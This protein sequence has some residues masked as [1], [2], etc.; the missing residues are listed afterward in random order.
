MRDMLDRF[1]SEVKELEGGKLHMNK[2]EVAPTTGYGIYLKGQEDTNIYK[3]VHETG[4][5]LKCDIDMG[6]WSKEDLEKVD[7]ELN[8]KD[9][10]YPYTKEFYKKYFSTLG[11]D[12][13]H[14]AIA[15]NIMSVFVNSRSIATL[16]LQKSYNEVIKLI[17]NDFVKNLKPIVEDGKIGKGTRDAVKAL[18]S[19][20]TEEEALCWNSI[21]AV[22]TCKEY[23]SLVDKKPTNKIY[24]NGWLNRVLENMRDNFKLYNQ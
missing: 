18:S 20:I 22:I 16:V 19:N 23:V 24:L 7:A 14:P 2:T 15:I 3:L 21:A 10:Y 17:D 8:N 13:M 1:L 11:I 4:L 9:T 6:K 12:G 5:A